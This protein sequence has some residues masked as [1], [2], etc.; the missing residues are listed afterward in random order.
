M[1]KLLILLIFLV[2]L[3][4]VGAPV[5]HAQEAT[6]TPDAG[7]P[8]VE[9]CKDST[10]DTRSGAIAYISNQDGTEQIY[11]M[12]VD[13]RNQQKI[14]K[15]VDAQISDLDWSPDGKQIAFTNNDDIYRLNIELQ[16][17]AKL[18]SNP[19]HDYHPAWSSDGNYIAYI[20][21]RGGPYDIWEMKPN[22]ANVTWL[23]GNPRWELT[24]RWSPDGDGFGYVPNSGANLQVWIENK[25]GTTIFMRDSADS[26]AYAVT[27][28]RWSPNGKFLSLQTDSGAYIVKADGTDFRKI[29]EREIF[30]YDSAPSWSP[31]SCHLIFTLTGDNSGIYIMNLYNGGIHQVT[32]QMGLGPNPVWKP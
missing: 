21:D 30:G 12:N 20:S 7:W 2:S 8:V 24:V 26:A 31:D 29:A 32:D 23:T 25:A 27:D 9:Q 1:Q 15:L 11:L 28:F 19:G 10:S 16:V 6:V 17:A 22:G 5:M 18:T 3:L 14:S 4:L 13:G